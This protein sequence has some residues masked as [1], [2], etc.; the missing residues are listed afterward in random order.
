VKKLANVPK[1]ATV[2]VNMMS[3]PPHRVDSA[4]VV[5]L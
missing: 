1:Q 3:T 2:K 5:L 4:K